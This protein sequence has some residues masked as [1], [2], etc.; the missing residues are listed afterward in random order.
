MSPMQREADGPEAVHAA[1]VMVV[2]STT[3]RAAR[4]A[5]ATMAADWAGLLDAR[6]SSQTCRLAGERRGDP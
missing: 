3:L 5:S 1:A 6:T 2:G 4:V